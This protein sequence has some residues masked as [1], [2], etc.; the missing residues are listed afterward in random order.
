MVSL[1][2]LVSTDHQYRRFKSLFNFKAVE[3]ELLVLETEAN[4]K[5]YGTLRLFKCLF[6]QFM[7]DLSDRELERYLADSTA[8]KWF[9]DF[10]L[11]EMIP[12]YSVF[13]KIRKKIGTNLL[14]KIFTN[15]RDQLRKQGYKSEVFTFVDASHLISKSSLWEECDELR[16]QKYDKLNNKSL[17]KVANDKRAKI[18]CKGG[19]K[20]WYGYKKHVSVDIQSGMINK[21]A[22]TPANVT[23]SKGFKHVMPHSGATYVD[24]AYCTKP[25]K[26]AATRKGVHLCAVKKNNMQDKNFDLDKYYTKIRAPFERVFSQDNKRVR[27]IGIVK[28]QFSEFMKAIC[29]NL[30]RLTVLTCS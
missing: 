15:F 14:S 19:N 13:S 20:F 27:Y 6:L 9:C 1:D 29:F 7:E 11:T 10:A 18:G 22:V 17:S 26:D 8:G 28:N 23:D 24:K 2:E 30:K 21:V 16:K 12:D 4:Y 5:G 25:V 3:R